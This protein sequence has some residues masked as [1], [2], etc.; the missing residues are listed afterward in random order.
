MKK[1][2][3]FLIMIALVSFTFAQEKNISKG[4]DVTIDGYEDEDVWFEAEAV[5]L[6]KNFGEEQ[7]TVTAYFKA[8]YT[9]DYLYV[10]L[11]VE[12]DDHHPH[13]EAGSENHW[14]WDKPEIYFDANEVHDDG[15]GAKNAGD[16][17]WQFAPPFAEENYGVQGTAED[18]PG[19]TW[20]YVLT[21]ENYVVEYQF[22]LAN[23]TNGDGESLTLDDFKAL[24]E[25]LGFDAT[26]IDQDEGI[27]EA[28]QRKVWQ[29]DG[30]INE[31]WANMD[32][33]GALIFTE[34]TLVSSK[35]L[36]A[37]SLNVY[38]NPVQDVM[39]VDGKFNRVVISN[40]IGQQVKVIESSS[41]RINV[42]DL[43]KGVYFVKAY[44]NQELQGTA[45]I[46]KN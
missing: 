12:D 35:D 33:A 31:A 37:S 26:V 6:E 41:R 38:P 5:P 17:H 45:K 40:I 9:E 21:G 28:R 25:G 42:S 16:G 2:Y 3:L 29:C 10:L 8:F 46:T 23:I 43:S 18:V 13:W 27:T 4:V 39:N 14:E 7:P 44:N 1:I 34:G 15:L 19:T 36:K 20:C 30:T 11:N 32:G 22:V 24:P